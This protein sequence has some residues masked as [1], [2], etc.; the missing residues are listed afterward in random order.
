VL[1]ELRRV[2]RAGGLLYISDLWLQTDARNVQR[3]V[4]DHPKYGR[5]GVFDLPEG[6]TVRHHDRPGWK[7]DGGLSGGA[8]RDGA[9]DERAS[10]P[11][12]SGLGGNRMAS[13]APSA[14]ARPDG[15][16][17]RCAAVS[18]GG[19]AAGESTQGMFL[20]DNSNACAS[21]GRSRRH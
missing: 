9:D 11:R 17:G 7:S 5:Y 14:R 6:V 19:Q 1:Q 20:C 15:T 12:L 16:C 8:G 18:S 3:Y 13:H 21:G 10:G 2:L 4:C